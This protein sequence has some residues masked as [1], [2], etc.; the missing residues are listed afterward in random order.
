MIPEST[1]AA[2]TNQVPSAA[3]DPTEGP[4]DSV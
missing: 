2:R 4:I 1:G 3:S